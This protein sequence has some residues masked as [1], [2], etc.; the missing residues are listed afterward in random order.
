MENSSGV[1]IE[2]AK[3]SAS[4]VADYVIHLISQ[5][6]IDEGVSEGITPLKLQKILYFAQAASLSLYNKKLFSENIEAWKYGPVVSSLY[7]AYKAKLNTPIISTT[8]EYKAVTDSESKEL[9][10]GIVELFNKYSAGELVNI[11]HQHTPWKENYKE[12]ENR[13]IPPESLRDYYKNIF[14]LK[15][16]EDGE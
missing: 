13:V 15:S 1:K 12:G 7:H 6:K 16:S 3:Y 9:I 10:E 4:Q 8:G 14:V 2:P 5:R 11:T